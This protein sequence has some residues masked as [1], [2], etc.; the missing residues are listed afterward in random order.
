[1]QRS[2]YE[3]YRDFQSLLFRGYFGRHEDAA[4]KFR[5]MEN[6]NIKLK[7]LLRGFMNDIQEVKAEKIPNGTKS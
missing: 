2:L 4:T 5:D 1:M 3:W 7:A 6:D